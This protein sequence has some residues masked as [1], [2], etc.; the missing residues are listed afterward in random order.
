LNKKNFLEF[1]RAQFAAFVGT[2]IDY[3]I[4]FILKDLVGVWYIYANIVGASAGA[5]S[6]FLL[7]R[8]WAFNVQNEV[9]SKQASKYFLV[10][11]GSLLL[12]TSGIYMLTEW[13][14]LDPFVSK[15]IVG[16]LVAFSFN[17]LLQKHFVFKKSSTPVK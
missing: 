7:G 8:Y 13:L 14:Q 6:N 16:I 11:L 5:I 9:V 12:N 3:S 2:L 10:S 4:F 1:L 15:I 17:F